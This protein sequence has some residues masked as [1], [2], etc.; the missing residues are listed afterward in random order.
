MKHAPL[1]SLLL[2]ALTTLPLGPRRAAA[3]VA[4]SEGDD[5]SNSAFVRTS[6]EVK[7]ELFFA[8]SKVA[9]EEW[10]AA[11]SAFQGILDRDEPAVVEFTDRV[12]LSAHEAVRRHL[13]RLPEEARARYREL[14]DARAEA[15]RRLALRLFDPERLLRVARRY[16]LSSVAPR[17]LEGASTLAAERGDVETLRRV[18]RLQR[19][20]GAPRPVDLA[21]LALALADDGDRAG[22][23]AL[24]EREAGRL[25]AP[26]EGAGT[27]GAAIERALERVPGAIDPKRLAALSEGPI[28]TRFVAQLPTVEKARQPKPEVD[29]LGYAPITF[30]PVALVEAG[31][32][33]WIAGRSALYRVDDDP[34][35]RRP[36]LTYAADLGAEPARRDVSGRTLRPAVDGDR[37]ILVLN[38]RE[39]SYFSRHEE[40]S[41]IVAF[42]TI[43]ERI[44]WR[45]DAAGGNREPALADVVFEGPAVPYGDLVLVSGSRLTTGTESSLFAFDRETGALRWSRF[46]ASAEKV[47]RFV[48]RNRKTTVV[49]Q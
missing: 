25:D 33:R 40:T 43:D 27:L 5:F 17:A 10:A 1:S 19:R 15:A 28:G 41:R 14:Y 45:V 12:H 3:Q 34:E 39:R 8:E 46:L 21:R 44:V 32:A 30:P 48:A 47:S 11:V 24:E 9:A 16:P 18:V 13:E 36:V 31:G 37:L 22:L 4:P 7:A 38:E 49:E 42:D 2:L 26:V 6:D 35:S 29:A 20:L 23:L